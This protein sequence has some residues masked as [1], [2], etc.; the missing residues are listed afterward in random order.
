MFIIAKLCVFEADPF[1]IFIKRASCLRSSD[2]LHLANFGS[3]LKYFVCLFRKIFGGLQISE[4]F[5]CRILCLFK[6]MRFCCFYVCLL[7]WCQCWKLPRCNW[8]WNFW[9]FHY[10][11]RE[12]QRI[13][14][15]KRQIMV[16]VAAA[17]LFGK[18]RHF[19]LLLVKFFKRP[20]LSSKFRVFRFIWARKQ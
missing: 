14:V 13:I 4:S 3:I 5:F 17:V 2:L 10:V 6:I 8:S 7:L 19:K 11:N 15:F 16:S 1:V 18:V 12:E 20:L 9:Q